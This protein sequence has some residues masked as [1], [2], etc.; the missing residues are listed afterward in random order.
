MRSINKVKRIRVTGWQLTVMICC[1]L[2]IPSLHALS[3][4][5]SGDDARSHIRAVTFDSPPYSFSIN[6]M[7]AGYATELVKQ[8]L[9][10]INGNMHIEV[11][12][13]AR[14]MWNLGSFKDCIIFPVT[15]SQDNESDFYW[16]YKIANRRI[17]LFRHKKRM[18]IRIESTADL[19]HYRIGIIRGSFLTKNFLQEGITNLHEVS[20]NIQNLNKLE[21]SRIDLLAEEE[22]VLNHDIDCYNN[23]VGPDHRLTMND[24]EMVYEWNDGHQTKEEV[25]IAAS[26]NMK[27]ELAAQIQYQFNQ[28][29]DDGKLLEVAHWWTNDIEKEMLEI[30][31]QAL[32]KNGYTWIDYLFEGGA[33]C[34]MKNLLKI[35]DEA[36]CLP[37]AIQTYSGPALWDWAK[38]DHL[39]YLDDVAAAQHWEQI[40]PPLV[41]HMIQYDGHY[42]AA[43]V[44][45]QR[46]NWVWINP[47][48][49]RQA[50][51]S[52]PKTWDAFFLA[53]ERIK[54][55]GFI[56]VAMG[57]E[58][59]QEATLFENM[60]L[61]I[62]G[63]DFYRNAF[64]KLD[65]DTLESSTMSSVLQAFRNIKKYTP[66]DPDIQSWTDAAQLVA[67]GKA[68]MYF[69]GDW[70]KNVFK[71]AGMPYGSNG[72][73]A[74]PV[75]GTTSV[76]LNNTDVFAFPKGNTDVLG[77][78][79]TLAK[80]IMD[81]TTHE[82]FNLAKGS[83]PARQDI[84]TDSF[85]EVSHISFEALRS[86]A[87][88]IPSF[89]FRQTVP[90]EI[91]DEMVEVISAFFNSQMT[92]DAV[93]S[94]FVA[95]AKKAHGNDGIFCGSHP[96]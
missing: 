42:V 5:S 36:G 50:N 21:R 28:L 10:A 1:A 94:Q 20:D 49:F 64:I 14:I 86:N 6:G 76:F 35:R 89:N 32:S 66:T 92:I 82:L 13:L 91:H 56:A 90:E 2:P 78:Q 43:P 11:L 7:R 51:A 71:T 40:L 83:L 16:L 39:I 72:Y 26:K 81:R 59:W 80:S 87:T 3:S 37:H 84:P 33:G 4:E 68:A 31:K 73:I 17:R 67:D 75:P 41:N 8:V 12:P 77:A 70:A 63:I 18:D 15:R 45:I 34:K 23:T 93:K 38:N 79:Q 62:G 57:H 85:D 9:T 58:P 74:I 30:Y 65:I 53:A 44:N 95:L 69:M 22:L 48:V 54:K 46:V 52:I 88:L 19:N 24:Y 96:N 60:A 61:G 27:P 29:K 25:Y 47:A 55:A